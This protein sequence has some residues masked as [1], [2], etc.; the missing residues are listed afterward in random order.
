MVSAILD[1]SRGMPVCR[2]ACAFLPGHVVQPEQAAEIDLEGT[3][4][5]ILDIV[6]VGRALALSRACY[7]SKSRL[8]V[9]PP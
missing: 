4:L 1:E 6:V 7:S 2:E 5:R 3:R 9:L 8:P